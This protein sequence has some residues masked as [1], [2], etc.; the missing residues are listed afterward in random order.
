M[1]K[2]VSGVVRTNAEASSLVDRLISAGFSR[3]QISIVMSDATRN[4]DFALHTGTK[5]GEGAAIGAA[6]GGAIVAIAAGLAA[7][8]SVII[9]GVG[10]LV[11]GPLAAAI[12]GAGAGAA[13]GGAVGGLIGLGI[14]E[15]EVR[16]FENALR[17]GAILIGVEADGDRADVARRI[18]KEQSAEALSTA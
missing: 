7:V 9:P 16:V 15:H 10:L 4:R 1:S 8:G 18:F 6:S 11:A 14:P 17:Q 13:V 12:A 2:L 5:A 3:S